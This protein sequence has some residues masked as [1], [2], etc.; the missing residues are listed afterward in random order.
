MPSDALA[1]IT[2]RGFKSIKS[3]EKLPLSAVNILVG[4]NGSGKSN[5]IGALSF[6]HEVREGRMQD[7]VRRSGG[8]EQVLHFG[9]K[10]T[11]QIQ[12]HVS[13]RHGLNQYE[14]DL[15]ATE[16]DSLFVSGEIIYFWDRSKYAL[17]YGEGIFPVE[18]GREA[19]I[20]SQK[21]LR[22]SRWVRQR[23]G[24]FRLYHVHDTS[25]SSPMRKTSKIDDNEFLRPDGANLGAFLFLLSKKHQ[26]ESVD[27]ERCP[28]SGA[29]L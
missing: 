3:I 22:I 7:Y 21:T 6:L 20:S 19:G 25:T 8:A 2:I 13:F 5:F 16:D 26:P 27:P 15:K 14:V 28:G 23:L 12:F 29:L 1:H 10:A 18:A 24:L 11:K 4:A 9:S 17:P